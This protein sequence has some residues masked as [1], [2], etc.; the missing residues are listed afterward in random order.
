MPPTPK[1]KPIVEMKA[2][3]IFPFLA[4]N[5]FDSSCIEEMGVSGN[6]RGYPKTEEETFAED[7]EDKG[8]FH[9]IDGANSVTYDFDE[10]VENLERLV[11]E[12][13]IKPRDFKVRF[14]GCE[15]ISTKKMVPPFH[16]AVFRYGVTN[17]YECKEDMDRSEEDAAKLKAMGRE[18]HDDQGYYLARGMGALVLPMTSDRKIVVG[19]RRSTEY[20]GEIHGPAGW[21]TFSKKVEEISPRKDAYKELQEEL[22]VS[23]VDVNDMHLLGAVAYPKTLETDVVYFARLNESRPSIYFEGGFWKEAVD[24]KEHRELITLSSPDEMLRLV[25]EGKPPADSRKM[26]V[27]PSTAYGLEVLARCWNN[28]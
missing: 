13:K 18:Y 3:D 6:S 1:L 26:K 14:D 7:E 5:P 2:E 19:V 21:L 4:S 10:G 28:I 17:F 15:V 9:I 11:L 22:A 8:T 27:I 25:Q 16:L 12:G 24:A 23:P 20:D